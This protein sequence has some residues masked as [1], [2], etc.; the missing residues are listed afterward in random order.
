MPNM[1]VKLVV[2]DPTLAHPTVWQISAT[3]R[4]VIRSIAAARSNR[5]VSR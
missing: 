5:L 2:N 1:R 4:S 3:R